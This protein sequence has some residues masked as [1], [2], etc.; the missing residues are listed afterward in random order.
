MRGEIVRHR[1]QRVEDGGVPVRIV[2]IACFHYAPVSFRMG[3]IRLAYYLACWT[4]L[5]SDFYFSVWLLVGLLFNPLELI[6]ARKFIIIFYIAFQTIAHGDQIVGLYH[7][8][9]RNIGV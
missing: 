2:A 5:P 6:V 3:E 8:N 7:N 4:D 9:G 1:M